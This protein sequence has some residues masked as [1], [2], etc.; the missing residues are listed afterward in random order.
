MLDHLGLVW[1]ITLTAI[2]VI[3]V[4]AVLVLGRHIGL[5]YSRLPPQGARMGNP[6]PDIGEHPATPNLRTLHGEPVLVGAGARKTL[7]VFMS[8]SCSQCTNLAPA[9]RS[10][11]R[12][13]AR[14]LQVV[15][16]V[17][18]GSAA[19]AADL[20]RA[21]KLDGVPVAFSP[22][23]ALAWKVMTT[24]YGVLL[25]TDGVVR[26]KGVVNNA[27]HLESLLRADELGVSSIEEHV[28]AVHSR[29][30]IGLLGQAEARE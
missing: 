1:G 19:E 6:G 13:E 2:N 18:R 12:S 30:H 17:T 3:L 10:I 4:L 9:V 5:I 11:H 15:V 29:E 14:Q 20:V 23:L 26:A 7:V 28:A 8:P 27:D 21:S 25:S 22:E 16:A 24:P